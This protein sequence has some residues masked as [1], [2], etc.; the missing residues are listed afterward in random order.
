[1]R[2]NRTRPLCVVLFDIDGTLVAGPVSDKSAGVRAMNRASLACTGQ[3]SRFEGA[4][5]AGRTD[6][7]IARMLLA[8]AGE[9]DPVKEKIA[10]LIDCYVEALGQEIAAHPFRALGSPRAAVT[11]LREAGALVGL[12]TG[13]VRRGGFLKLRSAGIADLFDERYGGFGEDGETRAEVL[14]K[15]AR[16]MD[17]ERALQ[18]VVVGDTPRDVAAALEIGASCV[19]VPFGRR[20][21]PDLLEAGAAAVVD[22]IDESL[23]EIVCGL[24]SNKN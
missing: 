7:E 18:V 23:T 12:G 10:Y 3:E 19:G 11:G 1:M 13:N 20:R 16:T 4:D 14:D 24:V 8:D 21:A 6:L 5:Y 17:P 2:T 15:G 22:N 9:T